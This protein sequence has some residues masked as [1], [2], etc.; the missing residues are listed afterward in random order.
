[1]W[2]VNLALAFAEQPQTVREAWLRD[3]FRHA[4]RAL[5]ESALSWWGS[6]RRLAPLA[7]IDGL[8]HLKQAVAEGRG[9]VL[10]S[11]HFTCFELAARLLVAWHPFM[12]L[13]KPQRGNPLF[14]AYTTHLRLRHFRRAIPHRDLRAMVQG[15]RQGEVCWY[16]PD[17]DFGERNSLFVPF[18]GVETATV[19]ATARLARSGARVVPYYPH[20]EA[21]GHYRL[22]ILPP[23]ESFPSGDDL[24]DT[25]RI[26]AL[27][28]PF[29]RA[30]PAQ[31]LWLHR[32]F[33]S[34]PKGEA[35]PYARG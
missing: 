10:L 6:D 9:V 32:R 18:M 33:K 1:L 17:Q 34:R 27:L 11:A 28:E 26:N 4:G 19:T 23:L 14:E 29:V 5:F 15:L 8:H 2:R 20:R 21:D 31:Y 13:Y 12:Y 30:E 22:T 7:R 24:A 25:R 35:D 3:H 16:L